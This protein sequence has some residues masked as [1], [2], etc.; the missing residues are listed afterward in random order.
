[1]QCATGILNL[2]VIQLAGKKAM[3]VQAILNS[4][5]EMFAIGTQMN[6]LE[7]KGQ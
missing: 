4:R 7:Q 1:V 5:K 3:P 6:A 2:E